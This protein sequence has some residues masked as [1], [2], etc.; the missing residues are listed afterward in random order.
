MKSFTLLSEIITLFKY[1]SIAPIIPVE[2]DKV[3]FN[4]QDVWRCSG[5]SPRESFWFCRVK[6]IKKVEQ[7]V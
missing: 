7:N 3:R 2:I 1:I 6:I 4:P 5:R